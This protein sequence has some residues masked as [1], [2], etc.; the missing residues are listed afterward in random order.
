MKEE[1]TFEPALEIQRELGEKK[2]G[3][4]QRQRN[5]PRPGEGGQKT[6]PGELTHGSA[7]QNDMEKYPENKAP[8]EPRAA[9]SE[10]LHTAATI[11][12]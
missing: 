5:W 11:H 1:V 3:L 8:E 9:W 12:T 2:A 7:E 4:W 6:L 10:K